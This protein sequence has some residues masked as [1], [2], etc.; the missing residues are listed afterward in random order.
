MKTVQWK[1]VHGDGCRGVG[2]Q[3]SSYRHFTN[4]DAD[5]HEYCVLCNAILCTWCGAKEGKTVVTH[6]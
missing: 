1:M 5:V 6:G 3:P 2:H 4:Y